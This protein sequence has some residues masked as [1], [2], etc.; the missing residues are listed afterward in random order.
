LYIAK[1][2]PTAAAAVV[3]RV[4]KTARQLGIFP[5]MGRPKYRAGVRMFPMRHYPY[6]IFYA[7]EPNEVVILNVRHAARRRPDSNPSLA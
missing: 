5:K 2:N 6:L 7:I 3:E 1:D 4:Q